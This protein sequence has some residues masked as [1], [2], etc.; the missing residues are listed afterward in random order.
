MS[1]TASYDSSPWPRQIEPGRAAS[2]SVRANGLAGIR[3]DGLAGIR[4]D[5]RA[6]IRADGRAGI[7]AD[8]RADA[9]ADG[10]VGVG[11]HAGPVRRSRQR[12]QRAVGG[13]TCLGCELPVTDVVAA[14]LGFCPRCQDF[15]GLCGAGRKLVCPDVMTWTTWHS[16]CTS[17]GAAAWQ[18][19]DGPSSRVL[20][21][22]PVHDEQLRAGQ[23]GWIRQAIPL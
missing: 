21:L 1:S 20:L 22:C 3:A 23:A 15:T 5:G 18:I 14:G 16:P 8:G 10:R 13:W 12:R 9:R 19:A 17:R 6:G 4:A 11:L 7:R 2:D